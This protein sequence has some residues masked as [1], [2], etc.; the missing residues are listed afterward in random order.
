MYLIKNAKA[1]KMALKSIHQ[2]A[3]QLNNLLWAKKR[4]LELLN[5]HHFKN[6]VICNNSTKF[7]KNSLS[8]SEVMAILKKKN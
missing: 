8:I 3:K 4:G 1:A 2:A 5:Q 6:W 7:D